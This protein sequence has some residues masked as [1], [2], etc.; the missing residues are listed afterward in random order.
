MNAATE[1][2]EYSE[3]ERDDALARDLMGEP[4]PDMVARA[5]AFAASHGTCV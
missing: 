1:T 2:V 4:A 3:Q 5:R